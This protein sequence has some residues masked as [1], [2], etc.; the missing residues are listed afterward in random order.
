MQRK[1]FE[2]TR[3]GGIPFFRRVWEVC[4]IDM[5]LRELS[6]VKRGHPASLLTFCYVIGN[7]IGARCLRQLSDRWRRDG[8]LFGALGE[9]RRLGS[10]DFSRLLA[11]FNF[12]PL[13]HAGVQ[14]LQAWSSTAARADTGIVI[15][16]DTPVVKTGRKME[17]S[18]SCYDHA[19]RRFVHGYPLVNLLYQHR[20]IS[21]PVGFRLRTKQ[22]T[23]RPPKTKRTKI[24]L[25]M[26]LISEAA[27]LAVRAVVFDPG[28]CAVKLLRHCD[29]VG[30]PWVTRLQS[31]RVV[32]VEDQRLSVK[33]LSRKWSWYRNDPA[34][35]L[36]YISCQGY[37]AHYDR[38]VH[39][40][41]IRTPGIGVQVLATSL[42][43][44]P[45]QEIFRLY[46]RRK[47][48]ET[49]HRDLKQC[50]GLADFRYRDL[51]RI[52]NHLALVYLR[53]LLLAVM[54]I[55]F[56]ELAHLPWLKI[57]RRVIRTVQQLHVQGQ[58]IRILLPAQHPL[59]RRLLIRY[60]LQAH[61]LVP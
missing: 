44:A 20:G 60:K 56:P 42:I 48:I 58:S 13:L 19:Q 34:R 49:F 39:I 22:R 1:L 8:Y 51:R 43:D 4:R 32:H 50:F 37:L 21:Y 57:K 26:E 7:L 24:I 36:S 6:I 59:F 17:G 27:H 35:G 9:A 40:V 12:E 25:A 10:H 2:H 61:P 53:Y 38:P 16:D 41:V 47:K 54:R 46:Q 23:G 11:R 55:A 15:L 52:H 31:N 30:T 3:F 33:Q 5:H 28:Y 18:H 45:W 29:D 14:Q